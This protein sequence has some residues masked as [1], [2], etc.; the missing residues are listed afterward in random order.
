MKKIFTLLFAVAVFVTANA[1]NGDN[2]RQ[3]QWNNQQNDQ[4]NNRN[5]NG[6][7]R[8]DHY[9]NGRK[10]MERRRDMEIARIN[11]EYDFRMER[12]RNNFFMNRFEKR[13]QLRNLEEQRDRE[14]RKVFYQYGNRGRNDRRDWDDRDD[15]GRH[16]HD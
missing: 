10:G 16:D 13:R 12:V 4:W 11:R 6:Y 9:N 14:I 7:G 3:G 15:R 1:Q 2:R 5:D 8:D